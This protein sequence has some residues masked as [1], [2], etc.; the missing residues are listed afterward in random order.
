MAEEVDYDSGSGDE[1]PPAYAEGES[2]AVESSSRGRGGGRDRKKS[3][4]KGRGHG[5]AHMYG[6]ERYEGRGGVFERIGRDDGRGG[7]SQCKT[8]CLSNLTFCLLALIVINYCILYL[9]LQL[10]RAGSYLL[11]VFMK[12]PRKKIFWTNSPNTG[13]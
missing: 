10:L 12:R 4:V 2:M 9:L 3:R 6:E 7:P 1:A 8:Y 5:S 11:L 13:M